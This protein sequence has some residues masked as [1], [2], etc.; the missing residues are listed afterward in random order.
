[1]IGDPITVSG[2]P[3][4]SIPDG[5]RYSLRARNLYLYRAML[6]LFEDVTKQTATLPLDQSRE[7][8]STMFPT[9]MIED[10]VGPVTTNEF[11]ADLTRKPVFIHSVYTDANPFNVVWR[12][13]TPGLFNSRPSQ[14][15]QNFS[16]PHYT[17]IPGTIAR[18][19]MNVPSGYTT[20]HSLNNV[21][22]HYVPL[23]TDPEDQVPE[24][25]MDFEPTYMDGIINRANIY[26]RA[27]S[28]DVQAAE[29][30]MNISGS[31]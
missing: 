7:I 31:N 19:R 24:D 29:T 3:V 14:Y 11:E 10:T 2:S 15:H 5:V 12:K 28:Q 25:E 16:D 23:P 1:M 30:F 26:A 27:D 4:V 9:Y 20:D 8:W 6:S 22:V 18:L 17:L 13:E 21:K